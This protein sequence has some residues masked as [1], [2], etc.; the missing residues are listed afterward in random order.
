MTDREACCYGNPATY[1]GDV[2]REE[3]IA[4]RRRAGRSQEQVGEDAGVDRTT[5]GTWERGERTPQPHQR[6]DYADALGISL[7]DLDQ[8]LTSIPIPNGTTP[9]WLA[10]YLGMEQSATRMRSHGTTV[11]EGL[12]QT[13]GYA[14][15]IARSVGVG[16]TP[17]SYIERNIEQRALRQARM[18][19]GELELSV[20]HPETVLRLRLGSNDTMAAQM[21]WLAELAERP[22]VTI[23]IIPFTA[24]QYEAMRMGNYKLLTHPW[25]QGTTI[26]VIRHEGAV[27][28]SGPDEADN[29]IAAWQ[30]ATRLALPPSESTALIRDAAEQWRS[31]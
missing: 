25:I 13:A 2:R 21:D 11:L 30:Q 7:H 29:Y 18:L 20:V 14:A 16:A 6:V 8:M 27:L 9:V 19:N 31:K 4:A 10:Q 23:Q 5:I 15:A 3:L 26:Y 22:N 17:D 24:G 12:L 1:D 28:V